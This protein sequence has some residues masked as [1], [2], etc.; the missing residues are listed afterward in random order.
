M[1]AADFVHLHVHTHYSLLDGA[2]R[3]PDL[4]NRVKEYQM[5]GVAITDHGNLF[6]AMEF[7]TKMIAAGLKPIIGCEVYVAPGSR[8]EQIPGND[9]KPHHLVLLCENEKGYRNL[10]R[11]VTLAYQEGF[12]YKP[13]IDKEL[14]Q[15]YNGG[16]IAMSAC[17]GG[18]PA[19]NLLR[20]NEKAAIEAAD[21]YKSL[22]TTNKYFLE[23]QSNGLPE[24][25]KANEG[26]IRISKDLGIK[27]VATNDCH[28]LDRKDHRAH[29]ALLCIQTGKLLSDENRMS[30]HSDELFFKSPEEMAH[31]FRDNPEA[32]KT[33]KEVADKC[34]LML[35]FDE[36]Y[37]PRFDVSDGRPLREHFKDDAEIGFQERIHA[38]V[39]RGAITT[40]QLQTYAERLDHEVKLIQQMGFSGYFLIVADFI[41]YARKNGIPVGPGRGS[42]AG[43]LAAY[44]LGITD[45][46]PIKYNLLFER[47]LNPERKSMPDIDVDFCMT[48]R[49]K[50]IEYVSQ[51]YSKDNVAQIITF[52]RMQA[53]AV[54][55]D[56]ARVM[57]LPYQEADRLAKLIPNELKIT[58]KIALEKEPKLKEA[59]NRPEI[60]ELFNI[61]MRLEGLVR[62]ASTHAA[63]IV[64]SDRPLVERLP[65]SIGSDKETITQFDMNWVEKIGLVKFDFLGLKTLTVIDQALKL[66]NQT[67]GAKLDMASIPLDDQGVFEMLSRGDTMGVF[68]LES[69]GMRDMLIKFKPS[70]FEDLIAILALFRPGPLGS[71]V[72]DDF[73]HRKHGRIPIEYP[74]PQLESILK[75]TYGVILYQEQVMSIAQIL[76]DYSLGEADLLRRAMG[77]KKPQEMAEQK[78]RFEKGAINN[79][80]DA[81]KASYIFDLMEKFAGYGFNKSHS[82]AYAL[83][84]YQTAYLKVHYTPEF[85]AAQLTCESGNTDKVTLYIS[86][87][88]GMKIDIQPPHVNDSLLNFNVVNGKIVFGLG[89]VKN[90]G[91]GAI[92]SIIEAR[93]QDG[94][95]CSIQDFTRR[96]DLRKV[97]KKVLESLI[98]CG[99]FDGFGAT[100]RALFESLDQVLERAA[101]FQ[102]E[103]NEG[104]FNLFA[105]ECVPGET[106]NFTDASIADLEEWDELIKLEH[107]KELM[108]FYITGHPLL[109]Y[110]SIIKR[111]T[112]ATSASLSC[113]ETGGQVRIAG[114]I[115]RIKEITTKKGDRMAFVDI[116]DLTGTSEV[117]VFADVYSQNRDLIQSSEPLVI[118]GI[119]EGDPDTPKILASEIFRIGEAERRFSKGVRIKMSTLGA[120]SEQIHELKRIL[121]QYKGNLPVKL[122]VLIPNRTETVINSAA[123]CEPSEAFLADIRNSFGRDSVMFE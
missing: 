52:G 48:G 51:K 95:F 110:E 113:I 1:M 55:R 21:W 94:P 33:T 10:C 65:L 60:A 78:T 74:L 108:G 105:T 75:E 7:Y 49:E 18:E 2:I 61:A 59:M 15:E 71:G 81:E 120:S 80:I 91:E 73:I 98:K 24:Q 115:K 38:L 114:L 116:E 99:A 23:I 70:V 26:L 39:Q 30:F 14:L 37:M 63:G 41:N 47:F 4:I 32:L 66:I 35:D 45:I 106:G 57:G 42:A 123:L 68:Q 121:Y 5:P 8:F 13:R 104:Q 53:K 22:F 92:H 100:R 118:L 34:S 31:D 96:V 3:I 12:Y 44:C 117:T 107:E 112:N 17:L 97:N 79:G 76:A 93:N 72:V 50:V 40:E 111:Y 122:H 54:I 85:M 101:S 27:L 82:A 19:A 87:C 20:G 89:A 109:N 9:H 77:K 88:R 119:R 16:L 90:I 83:V 29:E 84:A 86:E 43:S 46:D 6:G 56:V 28:Y 62:H 69:S 25:A 103:K 102:R 58:L 11:L 64:I 67:S 36:I